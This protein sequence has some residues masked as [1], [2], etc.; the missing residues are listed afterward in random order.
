MRHPRHIYSILLIMLALWTVVGCAGP[1]SEG[2]PAN[3]PTHEA[4]TVDRILSSLSEEERDCDRYKIE[5][6]MLPYWEGHVVYNET[7]YP[8]EEQDGSFLPISLLY[9][10]DSILSVRDSTLRRQYA[11][12]IDYSLQDGKLLIL[13]DSAIPTI[14]YETYYLEREAPGASF[15]RTG[16]G[17]I[18]FGEGATFHSRQIV[19][20]YVHTSEWDGAIPADKS[21]LLPK[22]AERLAN[23][24]SLRIVYYGDSI[25]TGA[26]S[27]GVV[28]AA[29]RAEDWCTMTTKTLESRFNVEMEQINTAVGGTLSEWGK[30][31]AR[32][33]AADH[34]PDLIFIAFGM[35]DGSGRVTV[36]TYQSNIRSIVETVRAVNP[37][38]EF[39]L[40]APM[41]ANAEAANFAGFQED[42]L[43]ALQELEGE[44]IAVADITTMHKAFLARK[45]YCDMTGNN[46][47]HPNDFLARL[48]A[49]VMVRT[50]A[51]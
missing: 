25:T 50:V 3:M 29:P 15:P 37:D 7:V 18:A 32:E 34:R 41:L 16:G 24:Q 46:V 9:R 14:P 47:N 12:G 33:R 31:Q 17:Y 35:N 49:Q 38:C 8:L 48:Y 5:Q 11:E 19:V 23:R 1:E 27:S 45:R 22:T 26:N 2:G 4:E 44:G 20:T 42:Y 36:P 21:G 43:A 40:V 10:A 28:G 51:G 13:E 30:L 6:Y 39:V